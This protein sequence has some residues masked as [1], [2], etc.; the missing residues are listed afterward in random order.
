VDLCAAYQG[1]R[2]VSDHRSTKRGDYMAFSRPSLGHVF[3]EKATSRGVLSTRVRRVGVAVSL[4][5][6]A[7]LLMASAPT[8]SRASTFVGPKTYYLGLGDSLAFGFQPNLNWSHGYVQQ[9]YSNLQ[10]HGTTS[11]TNYGCNGETSYTFV[12]GGCPYAY[13]LHN[14]YLGSQLNAAVSFIK[15]HA[16]K[17]SPVSLDI[18]A[19]D[20]LPDISGSNCTISSSWSTDLANLDSRLTGTILPKLTAALA[21]SGGIRTGDLVM[22]NYYDPFENQCASNPQVLADVQTLNQ[23]IAADAAQFNVPIAN[24]FAS[25]GGT[26]TP[27][28][29]ICNY[30][31]MCSIYND[32]HATS[33]GYGVIAGSFESLTGY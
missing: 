7:V 23:H 1:Q 22:M 31:W 18:G 25:F 24:V 5:L 13:A 12:H 11:L 21:N 8:H 32:I 26:T 17:V 30:T 14:Y 28:P 16:G 33:T 4:A 9:W 20:L 10:S 3:V 2:V 19:N 29:N 15:G 27:N 6:V